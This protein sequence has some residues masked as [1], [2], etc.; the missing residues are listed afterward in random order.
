MDASRVRT[1]GARKA[2]RARTTLASTMSLV[3]AWPAEHPGR[4]SLVAI[5]RLDLDQAGPEATS[6]IGRGDCRRAR[7][8]R[9]H[10]RRSRGEHRARSLPMSSASVAS[11]SAPRVLG[12]EARDVALRHAGGLGDVDLG[13]AR[14]LADTSS[15]RLRA[16]EPRPRTRSARVSSARYAASSPVHPATSSDPARPSLPAVTRARG[17]S[18]RRRHRPSLPRA[19]RGGAEGGFVGPWLAISAAMKNEPSTGRRTTPA[20]IVGQPESAPPASRTATRSVPPSGPCLPKRPA[21]RPQRFAWEGYPRPLRAGHSP[22]HSPDV[23]STSVH[24]RSPS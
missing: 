21:T 12:L 15:K 24:T 13:L 10:R 5:Q 22:A 9:R 16:L 14:S 20:G 23:G 11:A 6:S 3:P 19:S 7:L 1:P 17:R 4:L 8:E 18:A 2:K